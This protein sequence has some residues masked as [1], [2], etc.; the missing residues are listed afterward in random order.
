M[1]VV[2]AAEADLAAARARASAEPNGSGPMFRTLARAWLEHVEFVLG[3]KPATLRDY[4]SM[5]AEPGTPHR[6]GRG[7]AIGRIIAALGDVPAAEVTT[8][9]IEALLVAHAAT[10]GPSPR[11]G[12]GADRTVRDQSVPWRAAGCRSS[13]R[14]P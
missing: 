2:E 4:R 13:A 6:R 10:S 8:A 11:S 1:E 3:A 9:Q 7:V 5:L 14:R 12:R